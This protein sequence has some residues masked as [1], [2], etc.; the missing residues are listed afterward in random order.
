M[1]LGKLTLSCAAV[2]TLSS[3]GAGQNPSAP[4][5]G[6]PQFTIQARVPLTILDVVVTDAKGNPFRGLKQSDFTVLED[7]QEM[8]PNSFEEH[9]SDEVQPEP[10]KQ[11]L[12]PNTFT[13]LNPPKASSI[14]IL[15]LDNLN[16]PA[17]AQQQVTQ[18]MLDFVDKMA[19]GTQ[20][21]VFRLATHLSMLQGFTSDR[22]LLKAALTGK[23]NFA[24][25][26]PIADEP[27]ASGEAE[28]NHSAMQA[29]YTL[30]AMRQI[31]RYVSGMPSRK[32]LIWFSGSFPLQFPPVTDPQAFPGTTSQGSVYDFTE[33]MKSA[34]DLM[35]NAHIALYPID[36]RGPRQLSLN[37]R[38]LSGLANDGSMVFGERGTMQDLADQ[39]GGKFF[40]NTNDFVGAVEQAINLGS[41]FYTITYTPTNPALD[42]RFRTI[43]VKVDQP[44]LHLDYRNGY[45]AVDPAA[46]AHGIKFER[47]SPMQTALTRGSFDATQILFKVNAAQAAATE[48]SL[49]TNNQANPKQM[50]PPYRHYSITY[51]IDINGIQFT[52]APDGNYQAAFEYGIRV[53]NA[54]NGQIVNSVSKEAQ[55][56]L[57]P[58]AYQS[59]LSTG[60][61]SHDDIDVPATGDFFL[62]V[63]VHDLTTDRVGALE[64]PT[65][66]IAPDPAPAVASQK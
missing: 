38:T 56:I 30:T 50:K 49:P 42:T 53:Y 6:H 15:L 43:S 7:N 40:F 10:V 59:M 44:N 46:N 14:N 27:G 35:A 33:D 22:A 39:T 58:E 9:R 36:W 48:V 41:N 29:Q 64:I 57:S 1:H 31:A 8:K 32:N 28:G 13:N 16:T 23:S 5:A 34:T 60:A 66:S 2:L 51:T 55:P 12:P 20:V 21:A 24:W 63:A 17:Q 47:V 11:T 54:G 65:S 45:Y 25:P 52:P 37:P 26:T 3:L 62:R 18:R 4:A 19:S 61:V